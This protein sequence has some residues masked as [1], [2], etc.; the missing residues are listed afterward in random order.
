MRLRS[1]IEEK[2]DLEMA[3]VWLA[4]SYDVTVGNTIL[5]KIC[6][7]NGITIVGSETLDWCLGRPIRRNSAS[8]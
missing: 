1:Q 2:L 4:T 8:G 5:K 7:L 6:I 3:V